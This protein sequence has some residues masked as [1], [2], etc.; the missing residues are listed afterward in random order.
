ML[1]FFGTKGKGLDSFPIDS[2]CDNCNQSLQRVHVFQK[3]FHI[4]W[5]PTIPI[6]KQTVLVCMHCKKAIHEKEMSPQQRHLSVPKRSAAG[7]PAYMFTGLV[8]IACLIGWG[9]YSLSQE[10]ANTRT[11]I[12]SP[13]VND[14]AIIKLKNKNYVIFK[15][16][17]IENNKIKF[18]VGNY[19]YKNYFGVKT[20]IDKK[21]FNE[22]DYFNKEILEMPIEKYQTLNVDFVQRENLTEEL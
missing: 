3:Y 7:T 4:F 20:E 6:G 9:K 16:V 12:A 15:L 1:F 21:G 19:T 13:A 5:I 17:S 11:L 14:L 8:L 10:R 22:K 18:Q 2:T